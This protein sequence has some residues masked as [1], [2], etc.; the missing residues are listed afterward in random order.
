MFK[1]WKAK[2][3]TASTFLLA[4]IAYLQFAGIGDVRTLWQQMTAH[5]WF[6]VAALVSTGLFALSI[7][8]WWQSTR[9]TTKNVKA[10]V[11]TWLDAFNLTHNK[12]EWDSWIF[13]FDYRPPQGAF[14]YIARTK[15]RPESLMLVGR[16][17]GVLP[18]QQ[19]AYD[20][21]TKEKRIE[22]DCQLLLEM[23]RAKIAFYTKPELKGVEIIKWI[24]ITSELTLDTF[25]E[26]LN[27]IYFASNIVWNTISLWLGIGPVE[28]TLPS[29]STPDKE[30]SPPKPT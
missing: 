20:A 28:P 13:G 5:Y 27:E 3:A 29:S 2:L 7:R 19:K 16:I 15:A 6:L 1:N 10:K 18:A 30:A 26:A 23:G 8:Y 14:V 21:L 9:T 17:I 12:V 11:R 24:P 25:M 4:V 22:L